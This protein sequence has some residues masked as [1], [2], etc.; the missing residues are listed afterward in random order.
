MLGVGSAYA[1][2]Y[3]ERRA[4]DSVAALRKMM[5]IQARVRRDGQPFDVAPGESI[6]S[7][8]PTGTGRSAILNIL[9]R[10]CEVNSGTILIDGQNLCQ[11]TRV[12]L[13]KQ[14]GAILQP[15]VVL[16]F[17]NGPSLSTPA[18]MLNGAGRGWLQ[19]LSWIPATKA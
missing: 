7:C 2:L 10:Y 18:A 11:L 8:G 5:N 3:Q 19:G 13:R 14:I 17:V 9:T 4:A 16:V 15:D 6:G 1:G 12:G